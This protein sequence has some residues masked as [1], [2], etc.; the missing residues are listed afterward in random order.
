MP[1]VNL[2]TTMKSPTSSVGTIELEGI[3][4]GSTRKERSRK[5]IRITGKK[6]IEYSTHHGCL[7][8]GRR[9][10]LSRNM[11]SSHTRP[12]TTSSV[13]RKRAKLK[14]RRSTVAPLQHRQ[15]RLLRNLHRADLLHAFLAFFLLVEELA[16]ARDVAAV[17]LGQHVLA[18]RLHVLARD[19]MP[20]DR[21]L[22]R[23]VEH[24]PRDQRS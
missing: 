18:Q 10:F 22:H 23:H 11:S 6:L 5:T 4:N 2:F 21:R 19:D 3:L 14:A 8:S 9:R 17:A 24:L 20:A 15:E 13:N 7:A 16:L 1:Y 12:L